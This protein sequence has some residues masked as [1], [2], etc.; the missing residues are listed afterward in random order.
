VLSRNPVY[1]PEDILGLK[2]LQ[3]GNHCCRALSTF[4]M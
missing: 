3:V 2:D 1:P 4:A